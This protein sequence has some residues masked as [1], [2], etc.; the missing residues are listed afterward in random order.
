MFIRLINKRLFLWTCIVLLAFV[1]ILTLASRY[2]DAVNGKLPACDVYRTGYPGQIGFDELQG[3]A[4]SVDGLTVSGEATFAGYAQTANQAVFA[5]ADVVLTDGNFSAFGS[6]EML[7][8]S[9]F[10]AADLPSADPNVAVIS[11]QIASELFMSAD[12]TGRQV[13]INGTPFTVCGVYKSDDSLTARLAS[14]GAQRIYVPYNSS[15]GGNGSGVDY[16]YVKDSKNAGYLDGALLSDLNAKLSGKLQACALSSYYEDKTMLAQM[17]SLLFFVPGAVLIILLAV[18]I[19]EFLSA[20]YTKYRNRTHDNMPSR[21]FVLPRALAAAG[22]LIAAAVVLKLIMFNFYI[23]A[24]IPS[25]KIF[26][27]VFYFNFVIGQV[28]SINAGGTYPAAFNMY[29]IA[30]CG[31]G[32][33]LAVAA[34]MAVCLAVMVRKVYSQI[35]CAEGN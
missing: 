17:K 9:F 14:D 31:M 7:S 2:V 22:C 21:S 32:A 19:I 13:L 28:Q 10:G 20:I 35:K 15:L 12:V 3:A 27:P 18:F 16:I 6:F 24:F 23:P 33:A 30:F 8:G 4:S 29:R 1:L 5:P 11:D 34:G 25:D 26:D